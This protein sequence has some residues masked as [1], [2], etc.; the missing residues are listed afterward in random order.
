MADAALVVVV[1]ITTSLFGWAVC[2]AAIVIVHFM[3]GRMLRRIGM[4][5][6]V[7]STAATSLA[8]RTFPDAAIARLAAAIGGS[9][10]VLEEDRRKF[11]RVMSGERA[12][13]EMLAANGPD[14]FRAPTNQF[15]E[16]S[17]SDPQYQTIRQD[18][19]GEDVFSKKAAS[20]S[21]DPK[22]LENKP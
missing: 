11:A 13:S 12:Q 18:I 10:D 2:T 19:Q 6:K 8:Q 14:N 4:M 7:A 17:F 21:G 1:L 5:N 20:S 16:V 15:E 22:V 9:L 3:N